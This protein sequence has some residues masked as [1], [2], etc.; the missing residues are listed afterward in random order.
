MRGILAT[1][2]LWFNSLLSVVSF[3]EH[4]ACLNG[5][6]KLS[7][8]DKFVQPLSFVE[9]ARKKS[10]F[11]SSHLL[12][13]FSSSFSSSAVFFGTGSAIFPCF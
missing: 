5:N 1:R 9:A 6:L 8:N 10:R 3:E 11:L 4:V 13:F 2:L 12:F 7:T